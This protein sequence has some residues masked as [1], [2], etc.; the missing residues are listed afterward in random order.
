[1]KTIPPLLA[2]LTLLLLLSACSPFGGEC[3]PR[4]V[5]VPT[6]PAIIPGYTELDTS[7]GLHITGTYQE[8]DVITWRL[9]VTGKVDTPLEL[10]YDELRCMPKIQAMATII[11]RGNFEDSANWGGVPLNHILD[12]AGIQED[13]TQIRLVGADGYSSHVQLKDAR[14]EMNFL[15]YELEGKAVPILH[16]FPLRAAFP[17]LPGYTWVK[18]LVEIE[19]K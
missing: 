11:C 9:R 6:V 8:I 13:A 18:W 3:S 4:P 12:L 7:T 17:A 10:G 2:L 14:N 15:A 19:V 5:V 1:M 16:G